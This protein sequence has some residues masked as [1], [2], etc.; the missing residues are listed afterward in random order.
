MNRKSGSRKS[1]VGSRKLIQVVFLLT[2]YHLLLATC[3]LYSAVV[4]KAIAKVNDDVIL[5]SDYDEAV[6]PII[7]QIKKTYG[8]VMSQEDMDKK[9]AEI[10]KEL[11][12]QM[13]DQKLLLQEAKKKNIKVTKR[14]VDDGMETVKDRFKRKNGKTLTAVEADAEFN[15]E[16][17]K[18]NLTMA[19][20]RDKLREDIMVNKLIEDGV[21]RKVTPPSDDELKSYYE[22]NR[23][24]IDE[25]EKVSVRHILIRVEK[26]A[27]TKEKSQALNKIKE[28]QMKLKKGEDFAK[29]AQQYSEDPGSQKN[30]GD[31]GFIVRGMMVKN[32]EDTAF[33]TPV[34]E[35]SDYFET[36]F[37][38]H[39][40]K[41]DAKQAKQK[42][43]FE[44]VKL[45]LEK[46][47]LAEKRQE[48]YEKYIKNL[49][50]KSNISSEV[51]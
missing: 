15:S 16:L 34:G 9:I 35:I 7:S 4:N 14:E 25:P 3:C 28:V 6:N 13:I 5:Q 38:Y 46:Y 50:D 17:K 40:L 10:R 48:E 27:S 49:R 31:L 33:K 47:L 32:F 51:K 24:K 18:Q 39:I 30:G 41:V 37:G 21:V 11:L 26:N 23:D 42:R 43:S 36:E 2:T 12:D 8:E 29:L 19:K 45:N 1:E 22:K 44:D 20:F